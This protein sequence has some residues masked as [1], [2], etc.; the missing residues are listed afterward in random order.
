MAPDTVLPSL[1]TKQSKL[2]L[3]PRVGEGEE[4]C[5]W[6][7]KKT[8]GPKQVITNN[9]VIVASLSATTCLLVLVL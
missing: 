9:H 7:F 8:L 4:A 2:G 3:S 1:Q 5:H 6:V